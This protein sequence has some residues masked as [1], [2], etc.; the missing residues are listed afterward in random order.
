MNLRFSGVREEQV[1]EAAQ[2]TAAFLRAAAGERSRTEILGPSPAPL[3]R[4]KDRSR[5]QLLLKSGSYQELHALCERLQA[6]R[7][8]L[9]AQAVTMHVDVDP[10]NMM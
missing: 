1:Q 4:I 2:R 3:A 9:F 7:G 10:E 6:E 5:W 8:R